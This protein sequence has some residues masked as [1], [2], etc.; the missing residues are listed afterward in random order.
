MLNEQTL[1]F[2]QAK[3]KAKNA[4]RFSARKIGKRLGYIVE[5]ELTGKFFQI[6]LSQYTFLSLLNGRR[7][8]NEALERTATLLREHA[9]DEHE[10]ASLCTVSY[11]HL[12]LPTICSV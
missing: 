10:V 5:D 9:F 7:T 1:E 8:V 4:L 12:T 3:L 6:G 11:T 2:G